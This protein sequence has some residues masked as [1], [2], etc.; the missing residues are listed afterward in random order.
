MISGHFILS[1]SFLEEI[2][3]LVMTHFSKVTFEIGFVWVCFA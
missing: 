3:Q 2:L 1:P